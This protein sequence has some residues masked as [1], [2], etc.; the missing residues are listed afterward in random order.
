[1]N[2]AP[3][4]QPVWD[5]A[6]LVWSAPTR[7]ALHARLRDVAAESIDLAALARELAG[8]P[9]TEHRFAAVAG[10][11]QELRRALDFA[12][13]QFAADSGKPFSLA[14]SAWYGWRGVQPGGCA[15]LFPGFGAKPGNLAGELR[16]LFPCV[17][18]W[19]STH[20]ANPPAPPGEALAATLNGLLLNDLAMWALFSGLGLQPAALLGHSYGEN[21]VLHAAGMVEDPAAVLAIAARLAQGR[22]V[23]G[24]GRQAMLAL[25]AASREL[26]DPLLSEGKV[27]VA[28]DNCPQQTVVWG[29]AATLASLREAIAAR[30]EMAF[31]LPGL[32]LPAHTPAFPLD[33]AA[34]AAIYGE[35]SVQAPCRAAWSC[36]SAAPFPSEVAAI[37]AVLVEQWHNPVRFRET[38]QKLAESGIRTFLELGTADFLS[39]F[40]RDTLRG[41]EAV[42][43]AANREGRPP[44][45]QVQLAVAQLLGRGVDL[46]LALF[47]EGAT[48]SAGIAPAP[49]PAVPDAQPT[50][51]D[52]LATVLGETRRL[53][54]LGEDEPLAAEQG[55]F[56]LGLNSLGC[57]A[58]VDALGKRCGLALPQTLPFDYPTPARLA[59]AI[60]RMHAP[61][62]GTEEATAPLASEEPIAIVGTGCRLPGGIASLE[63]L[64]QALAEGRDLVGEV[65]PSRWEVAE[66]APNDRPETRRR[67]SFGAFLDDVRGF[68]AEFFGISPREALA[69]DPQ[70]R[71][72]LEVS[73]EALENA[74]IAPASLFDS[75]TAIFVGISGNDY[76]QRLSPRQRLD[77]GG[78]LGTGNAASTAAGR[79][80]FTLGTHGPCLA[81]DTAC[82]SS[83]TALHLACQSLR[84]GEVQL[85]VAAGVNLLLNG[86]TS[87]F[88]A[89]GQALSASGRC[90]T[91]DA[92]AD[93][94][95][96][97]EGA[98]AVVLKRL[99]AALAAHDEILAVVHG[100]ALN[101]DGRT[102]GLT[103]P[104]GLAQQAVIRAALA[105]AGL[106]PSQ[107]GAV[108]AHGTGTALGDPIEV[109]ALAA[110]YGEGRD[111]AAPLWIGS[112]KSNFGHLEAAAGLA[113]LLKAVAQLRHGELAASLHVTTLNP[114]VD[115]ASLPLAVVTARRTWDERIPGIIGV[116]AFG[117]SGTNAHVLL[118]APPP[119]VA[120]QGSERPV[121]V[122]PLTA[123][124]RAALDALIARLD[125]HL[126]QVDE[127][128]WGA[129]C[130][131]AA[132]GRNLFRERRAVVAPSAAEA[133][134]R[135]A[136]PRAGN[137]P[138]DAP[139]VAF[140]FTGQ[141]AQYPGMG[142]EL[143]DSEPLFR[144]ELQRCAD[145]YAA[146][147]AGDL[148]A[149]MFDPEPTRIGQTRW[150]QP[151]LFAFEYALAQLWR[152]WGVEPA[153]LLGH[154]VGEYVAATLAGVFSLEDALRLVIRRGE[155][156]QALPAGGGMLAVNAG[157]TE[158]PGLLG[159][160]R[161][162]LD[163]AAINAP[164]ATVLSGPL[165]VI[166]AAAARLKERGIR[167]TTL[168]V[169]HAFHSRLLDPALEEFRAVAARVAYR[170]PTLPLLANLDGEWGDARMAAADYWCAQ[171][172]GA[173][174]FSPALEKLLASGHQTVCLE[175]GPRPILSGLG[176]LSPQAGTARWV[177]SL[178]ATDGENAAL[179]QAV[180]ALFEAGCN[181]DWRAFHE[182][183]PARR[184]AFPGTP[185][186]RVPLWLDPP[187]A[188]DGA[189][190]GT[191][192]GIGGL[193]TAQPVPGDPRRHYQNRYASPNTHPLGGLKIAGRDA[194]PA[195][196]PLALA[197]AAAAQAGYPA[198]ADLAVTPAL[199]AVSAGKVFHLT[200]EKNGQG[201]LHCRDEANQ[202]GWVELG[203][204]RAMDAADLP[205]PP[206]AVSAT[207]LDGARFYDGL[208]NA[209]FEY[210]ERHRFL[211]RLRIGQ[212]AAQAT[213]DP[214]R[215]SFATPTDMAVLLECGF[216][217][218][219]A[220]LLQDG[221]SARF[222]LR[223]VALARL[224]A[225]PPEVLRVSVSLQAEP[226]GEGGVSHRA[227]LYIATATGVP[228][229]TLEGIQLAAQPIERGNAIADLGAAARAQPQAERRGGIARFLAKALAVIL[230]RNDP[231]RLDGSQT[232]VRMGVDSLLALQLSVAVQRAYAVNVPVGFLID[233][234]TLDKLAEHI[235]AALEPAA[236]QAPAGLD[237]LEG[238]L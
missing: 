155:L 218:L 94:Y 116:S 161:D 36:A 138:F 46:D 158:L 105:D 191:A 125:G 154:S 219:A 28:L 58:L 236:A 37:R 80:A 129:L 50:V 85:A 4:S 95:V 201:S 226:T 139:R 40:V 14:N 147:G 194:L 170:A 123:R 171:L 21:A 75:A 220:L 173:V 196:A 44:L 151:C 97:G 103:V 93:G 212:N 204:F 11:T 31:E 148:L 135:L 43:I 127:A 144:A 167:C 66:L 153:V 216:Q 188:N 92:Q 64:W 207:E 41:S 71:L 13:K 176:G 149:V 33:A 7:A 70:Q 61:R 87:I 30:G 172:R 77:L 118:G 140:L 99:S 193:L 213:I 224:D 24:Q 74:A 217:L 211:D 121:Q 189:G 186:Q 231:E 76:A 89:R 190:T 52:H 88:L 51:T 134:T 12:L 181:I 73:W 106:R 15:V 199:V 53:L 72:L 110:V 114:R 29:D 55:F 195:S 17:E 113:G 67:A 78:Y 90:R 130:R 27:C 26:L 59:E 56:D 111:P 115:W 60:A 124:N 179:M 86:E 210:A 168:E 235:A 100:S 65:P 108:E 157:E 25:S 83:L 143:F 45:R 34:L 184:A 98:I 91:F 228:V 69:L 122:L 5:S 10:T 136:E 202:D 68:D 146:A 1:M 178:A 18:R 221:T 109:Q 49:T 119:R 214:Q 6:L 192:A 126:G 152:G 169:S 42:A 230:Q 197:L 215:R 96:R 237:Y 233:Q 104:N 206:A 35:L 174:R 141:G 166:G 81:V 2:D 177:A 156:I 63:E 150:T 128:R 19:F 48:G 62:R 54:R 20:L 159:E 227:A 223:R 38:V 102:S 187:P 120:E 162:V 23:A 57:V 16:A 198:L 107:V 183:R 165:D 209:A 229:L 133:R 234:C 160:L 39:G 79:L 112:G 9:L 47:H 117:I 225:V 185:F 84:R 82:S 32:T 142:R 137:P 164:Q 132:L 208:R 205:A 238:E 182:G 101:H 163:L 203:S 175:I 3:S 131:A 145:I 200:V 222:T 8:K 232:L 180:A 22:P